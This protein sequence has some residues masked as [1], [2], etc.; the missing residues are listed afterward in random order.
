MVVWHYLLPIYFLTETA[1]KKQEIG[2]T[3]KSVGMLATPFSVVRT[4]NV[5]VLDCE[6]FTFRAFW[7]GLTR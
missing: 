5:Y 1:G 4:L 6:L 2:E 3:E 7:R